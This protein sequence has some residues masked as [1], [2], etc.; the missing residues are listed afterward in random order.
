MSK[1]F[2]TTL[3]IAILATF[4]CF[5]GNKDDGSQI[6][7]TIDGRNITKEEFLRIY[8]K[9]NNL[10]DTSNSKS[11]DDY[12]NLF[13]NFKLKVIE[14]ENMGMDTIPEFKQEYE[15]YVNQLAKSYTYEQAIIDSF[16]RDAYE[17]K[18][19]VTTICEIEIAVN[20]NAKPSDTLKAYNR[21]ME[22]RQK[23]LNGESFEKLAYELTEDQAAKKDSGYIR[24]VDFTQ[25]PYI[26]ENPILKA[27]VGEIIMP[28]RYIK[29]YHLFKIESRI[30]NPGKIKVAHILIRTPVGFT[31]QQLDSV[32]EKVF[33]IYDQ[34]KNGSDFAE[35]ASV[36]SEDL[37]TAKN[38]GELV[39][40]QMGKMVPEFED[41]AF[42]LQNNGDISEPIK[43]VFGWHIIKRIDKLEFPLYE[44]MHDELV[45]QVKKNRVDQ[46]NQV[47]LRKLEALFNLNIFNENLTELISHTDPG[48][49]S[50]IWDV[51]RAP[52]FK[53][54]LFSYNGDTLT[55]YDF[56]LLLNESGYAKNKTEM[57]RPQII[58]NFLNMTTEKLLK[59]CEIDEL[60]KNNAEFRNIVNEY[61][62]GILLF[63]LTEKNVWSKA[64][65]DSAG[66]VQ[67]YT[68]NSTNYKW[69]DRAF[70]SIF[71]VSDTM[72]A[73]SVRKY[74]LTRT[75]DSISINDFIKNQCPSEKPNCISVKEGTFEPGD[76][77][78]L[79]KFE[80]QIG[81]SENKIQNDT[82][83][84]VV[85]DKILP[86]SLKTL[87]EAKGNVIADYQ[88]FL[89]TQ[90]IKELR[91]K[92]LVTINQKVLKSIKKEEANN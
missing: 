89:E 46:I 49:Y 85:I 39:Y 19:N 24:N 37:S 18:K 35:M 64:V 71:N 25:S 59:Q 9:N 50:G 13:V 58:N 40:F 67:Y 47:Y 76:E 4:N 86:A 91:Q 22:I 90:W 70:A 17:K 10:G 78:I 83:T 92:Y 60:Y 11:V 57:T 69:N 74:A 34:I 12:M 41:A 36:Y 82:V 30:P 79:D 26:F 43:T 31:P 63:N 15:G 72:L 21:I 88:N 66:L 65:Q 45:K 1:V 61:H 81:I 20:E 29:G 75:Q 7:M 52:Y 16:A 32:K 55:Q 27:Q 14:A 48:I 53:K 54:P 56:I 2:T 44:T 38:G 80:W 42:A 3:I 87:E 8:H 73:D 51:K 5:S 28:I 33:N 84:F 6:L 23:A 68:N 77:P 62:D